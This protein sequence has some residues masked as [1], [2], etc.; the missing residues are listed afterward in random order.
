MQWQDDAASAARPCDAS[1]CDDRSCDDRTRGKELT[2]HGLG[3]SSPP[4]ASPTGF[5]TPGGDK[6]TWPRLSAAAYAVIIAGQLFDANPAAC[7]QPP[8]SDADLR[9]ESELAAVGELRRS[10]VQHDCR[11]HFAQK[12]LRRLLVLGDDRVGVMRAI[13]FDMR[14][15]A[16]DAIDHAGG[17]DGVEIF[18]APIWLAR[19]LDAA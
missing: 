9:A 1:S 11:I 3:K 17:Q 4:H 7:M 6:S 8:G 15:G 14:D 18:G 16:V 5:A 2:I 13:T 10:I 12:L 19:R